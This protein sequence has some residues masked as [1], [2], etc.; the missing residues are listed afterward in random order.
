MQHLHDCYQ[1]GGLVP[2]LSPYASRNRSMDTTQ[3]TRTRNGVLK[4]NGSE[5]TKVIKKMNNMKK[6]RKIKNSNFVVGIDIAGEKRGYHG[7]ILAVGGKDIYSLFHLYSPDEIVKY[8]DDVPGK[9]VAIAID[10][11]PKARIK[12]PET[13]LAERELHRDHYRVQWTRRPGGDIQE[14]MKNGEKLWSVLTAKYPKVIETFPTAASDGLAD[15][16]VRLG[17]NLLAGKKK[18]KFYKDYID[19]CICA[20][21]AE[22]VLQDK[23]KVYGAGGE[24]GGIYTL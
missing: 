19:A 15:K 18:R 24:L 4:A 21:V 12:G 7:A 23:A 2:T 3:E 20:M 22:A 1:R 16:K 6:T 17:L 9:C 14:W 8:I 10:S 11:P 13:R 5:N